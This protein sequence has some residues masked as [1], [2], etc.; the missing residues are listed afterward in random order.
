MVIATPKVTS[1]SKE[2]KSQKSTSKTPTL[3]QDHVSNEAQNG[4]FAPQLPE[5]NS[6]QID[7]I[8]TSATPLKSTSVNLELVNTNILKSS[9]GVV[10]I[11]WDYLPENFI[12]EE[13]PVENVAQPLLAAALRESL[14]LADYIKPEMLIVSNLAICSTVNHHMNLKAPDWMY[15]AKVLPVQ[16]ANRRSYTPHLEGEIPTVVMEFLSA[17]EGVEYS[18]K[19]SYPLGKWHFYERIIQVPIYVIFNPDTGVLQFY[20]LKDGNYNLEA[21]NGDRR[22]WIEEMQLFLGLWEG[23]KDE[24]NGNWLRW[25]DRDG[26]ILLWGREKVALEQQKAEQE[27]QRAEQ[28]KLKAEQERARADRL[29]EQL[30]SLGI[31]PEE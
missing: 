7:S 29:L 28:E 16:D 31:D 1:K 19:Q 3:S 18:S 8:L 27:K 6:P 20:R 24:H 25:W 14:A 17:S 12:L 22:Y 2:K 23:V 11:S 26:N 13:E 21:S 15:V 10:N 30:R 9:A 4:I 5:I